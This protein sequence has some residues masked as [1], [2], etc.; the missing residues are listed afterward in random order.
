MTLEGLVLLYRIR[1]RAKFAVVAV[2]SDDYLPMRSNEM[3]SR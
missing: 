1:G 3:K 2:S